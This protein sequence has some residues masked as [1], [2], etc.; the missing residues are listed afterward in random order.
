MNNLKSKWWEWHKKN[1]HIFKAF[2][3]QAL[4]AVEAGKEKISGYAIVNYLRWE[5]YLETEGDEFKIRNDWIPFY[6]RLFQ[7]VHPEHKD[8][9]NTRPMKNL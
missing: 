9:F 6:V 7:H 4:R 8:L 3:K 1:P 2:E 5:V